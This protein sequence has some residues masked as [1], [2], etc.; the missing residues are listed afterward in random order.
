MVNG[1]MSISICIPQYNRSKHLLAVLE[2]IRLQQDQEVEVV[3]SDDCSTD[4]S[5]TA[6]PRYI[7]AVAQHFPGRI[8]YIR[9]PKNLG[10]DRNLRAAMAGGSCDYLLI[11][12]N[13][14]ALCG[15]RALVQLMQ[16]LDRLGNPDVSFC[17]FREGTEDGPV[18]VRAGATKVLGAGISVAVKEFRCF[19]F[20][21]GLVF[22]RSAFLAHDTDS[23]D[24]SVFYQIYLAARIIAAGGIAASI[25]EPI[26]VKDI[27][28]D[29]KAAN[30][31]LD[32]LVRD[33]RHLV[34]KTGGLDQVGRVAC[35]AIL[36][37]EVAG[38]RGLRAF[39][40]YWQIYSFSYPAWLLNYRL[41]GAYR[42][43]LNLAFGCQPGNLLRM[44]RCPGWVKIALW[45]SYILST[46]GGMLAPLG[47]LQKM[48]RILKR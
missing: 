18:V 6:I 5:E 11:L 12:G 8:N 16:T 9:Q 31:Y 43:A 48:A 42:A 32:V 35:D 28:V 27:Q 47:I 7:D 10:Y 40:I 21:G 19:S 46:L 23:C 44:V 13:D 34:P 26:V 29:G 36:P 20:V 39:Q 30:S 2:S 17:N 25:T 37:M 4:D 3:V 41:N 14:D 45:V 22:K 15:R 38:R 1:V 33:N 24:Q